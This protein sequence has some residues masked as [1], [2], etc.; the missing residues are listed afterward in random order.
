MSQQQSR[1]PVARRA[2]PGVPVIPGINWRGLATVYLKE[3]RRFRKVHL[4]TIWA[5]A[6]N[7]LLFLAIF[8]VA[9]ARGDRAV[10]GVPFHD[11]LAPGLIAMGMMQSAFANTSSSLLSAKVQGTIVDVLMPPL[12]PGELLTAY[13][14]S[15]VTRAWIVGTVTFA[16]MLLWP[17]VHM[18]IADPLAIIFF[19][20]AGA[21]FL[22]LLGLL[23]G[24]WAEKF[25]HAAAITNFVV[26]PL[27]LLS[28]TFYT[29]DRLGESW[30]AASHANPI[31]YVIDGFRAGFIGVSD[32]STLLG[33]LVLLG[34]V[35]VLSVASYRVLSSGWRIKA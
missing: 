22:S 25:D 4:Q 14:A 9:L 16:A 30:A 13:V 15:A 24:L 6:V 19:G 29:V 5:P 33:A 18:G 7:T 2:E 28:G 21:I 17:Q 11:F 34:A 10:M 8:S 23:T 35:L 26:Q 32:S 3:V 31:F 1:M 27:T 20:T 12:S